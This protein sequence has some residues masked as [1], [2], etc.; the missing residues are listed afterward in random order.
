MRL[1]IMM[2]LNTRIKVLRSCLLVTPIVTNVS[3][4]ITV[5]QKEGQTHD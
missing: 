2:Q 3:I 1:R 5:G 4:S